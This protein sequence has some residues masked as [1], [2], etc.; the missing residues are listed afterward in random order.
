MTCKFTIVAA[1]LAVVIYPAVAAGPAYKN[2]ELPVDARVA[3][4]LGRM[5]TEE[6][7]RQLDLYDAKNTILTKSNLLNGTQVRPGTPFVAER[8]KRA[9][10]D[11][12]LGAIHELYPDAQLY[13][14][15]QKWVMNSSRLGIPVLLTGEA[16]HGYMGYGSTIFPQSVNL[17]TTWNTDLARAEGEAIAS[18]TRARGVDMIFAPVLDVARE[19]RW[20]RVEEDFGEDPFL[21]GQLG[22]AYV[23]GVQ[24]DSLASDHACIAEPKHFAGH[25][26]PESGINTAPVHAGERELRMDMLGSFEPAIRE[27][28]AMGVMVAYNDIDGVPCT[29]NPWLLQKVLCNEWGFQGF[30]LADDGAIRRLYAD[31][32][33]AAT[34]ADAVRLAINSGVDMQFYDFNHDTFQNALIDGVKAG[35]VSKGTLD[36]AVG[37]IL[38][39]KFLLGL[40]DHPFVD[41][42]LEDSVCRSRAHLDLSLEVARQSMCLLKNKNH[43]LPLDKNLKRI[44][45]IGPNANVVQTG[46]YTGHEPCLDSP[47]YG[48]FEQVKRIVSPETRVQFVDGQNIADAVALATN[49]D[50]VILGLGEN[51]NIS[52]EGHDRS[53]LDLPG[54]QEQLLEAVVATGVP[55]VLVLENG[56][57][58]TIPWA[59]ENVPAILEAWYPGEFGGRAIAET[60]FGDNNPAG[61]LSISFPKNAGQLPVFYDNFPSKRNR[62]VDGDDSPQFV[63]GFGLSYTTFKYENL[64]VTAPPPGSDDDVLVTFDLTN[65]G[66]RDGDEVA[67][68]YVRETTASVAMPQRELKAFSRV[69]LRAGETR[70]VTLHIQRNDLA[71]W[72]AKQAWAVEPG[73]FTVWVGGDSRATLSKKF[74]LE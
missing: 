25:G 23:Q 72:G 17:A 42:N 69:R 66:D 35:S 59:A 37:R 63:F 60:L 38:R 5:T 33:V 30:S 43:L 2:S 20:G 22:L 41:P 18:E 3:D 16:L 11:L 39:A 32:H 29:A 74:N 45:V 58:L 34:P 52:G 49:S 68:V 27:G 65:A 70:N 53:S 21:S 71:I 73:E 7:A 31:H 48:I 19:P 13:N 61:R 44:A 64:N 36:E 57:P 55:V 62:Y 54:N 8:A 51:S 24:G 46:D 67:Q 12:G 56:R 10:G 1:S 4:L 28:H 15:L 26:S 40:F 14:A 6:K 9:F 47:E 50:A